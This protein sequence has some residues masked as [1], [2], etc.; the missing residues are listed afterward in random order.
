[1]V[2]RCARFARESSAIMVYMLEK[3][4]SNDE[5]DIEL[6]SYIDNKQN[7]WFKSKDIALILG[8]SDT[9][10]ALRKYI[11]SEDKKEPQDFPVVSTGYSQRVRRSIFINEHAFTP[12]FY[13][14]N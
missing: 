10:R 9:D 11:E 3:R 2:L 12:S 6:T 7:I 1:M 8:Y 13:P 5:L 4:F 14:Q